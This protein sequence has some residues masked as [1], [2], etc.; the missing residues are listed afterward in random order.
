MTH[1]GLDPRDQ[2][3]IA[4]FIDQ[5]MSPVDRQAFM[6]RLDEEGDLYEVFVETV[7]FRDQEA[8]RPATVVEHPAMRRQWGRL[9]ALAAVLIV[10]RSMFA[11]LLVYHI[12]T[13]RRGA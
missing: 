3:L 2:E 7:R 5:R 12:A 10:L 1:S 4:A 9:A 11:A 8:G 6:Q 13:T